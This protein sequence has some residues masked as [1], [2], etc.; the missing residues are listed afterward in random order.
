MLTLEEYYNNYENHQI[1]EREAFDINYGDSGITKVIKKFLNWFLGSTE[2]KS[3]DPFD[4][5][6]FDSDK[7]ET[8]VSNAILDGETSELEFKAIDDFDNFRAAVEKSP[9]FLNIRKDFDD[10]VM[11]KNYLKYKY[12]SCNITLNGVCKDKP[13]IFFV[14]KVDK[15]TI[16]IHM[17][18]VISS[19]EKAI[20]IKK[21]VVDLRKFLKKQIAKDNKNSENPKETKLEKISIRLV[22]L[23]A[24]AGWSFEKLIKYMN[25]NK[26]DFEFDNSGAKDK[27]VERIYITKA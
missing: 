1:N 8:A 18:E 17:I 21:F 5:D 9:C 19:F 6:H 4:S 10:K 12:A 25:E 3:Y 11:V 20:E 7:T 16:K 27:N 14:Y 26:G 2:K 23:H 24:K 22:K 13:C 15:D